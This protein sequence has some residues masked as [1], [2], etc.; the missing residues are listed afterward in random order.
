MHRRSYDILWLAI[1]LLAL[2]YWVLYASSSKDNPG[3]P[4][5]LTYNLS[6]TAPLPGQ[7][8]PLF[9]AGQGDTVTFVLRSDRS[10]IA[11]LHGYEKEVTLKPGAA[12]TLTVTAK[13][14]GVFPLHLHEAD[15]SMSPLAT[16]EVQ[17]R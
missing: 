16:L 2:M 5:S 10:G 1:L 8:L 17:P 3:E 7:A 12:V 14:A 13:D 15:G 11:H 9:R 4:R 6:I